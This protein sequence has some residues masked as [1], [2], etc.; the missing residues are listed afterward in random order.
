MT[1]D[2]LTAYYVGLLII[3]YSQKAKARATIDL[4]ARAAIADQLP[5]RV[6]D[7]FDLETAVGKQLDV[8]GT[9][10]GAQRYQY[11][12][13]L[14]KTWFCMPMITDPNRDTVP[15]FA[16]VD[17][18]PVGWYF[19]R[20]PNFTEPSGTLDDGELRTLIEYFIAVE[21]MDHTLGNID[22]LL[23][24]FFDNYLTVEED[25][26]MG[27]TYTH[28]SEDPEKLFDIVNNLGKFPRPAGVGVTVVE[29]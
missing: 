25:G 15:G 8:L 17:S 23:Y 22:D 10:V 3:Q 9:Y 21:S 16:T 2:E 4:L 28:A 29:S 11:G 12:L 6:R 20:I 1:T 26:A 18:S 24:A 13:D 5:W 27:I 7:A 19:I 14:A